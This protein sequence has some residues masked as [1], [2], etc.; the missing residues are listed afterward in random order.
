[1]TDAEQQQNTEA[2]AAQEAA[3]EHTEQQEQ[4]EQ[5]ETFDRAYVEKLRKENASYRQRAKE[6]QEAAE[7]AKKAAEREKLDEV[8]R[9]KAEKADLEKA[10]AE[11]KALATAA[12][13]RASLTGKVA[14]PSA[15]LKLLDE[16]EHLNEDGTVN[17]EALLKSFPFLKPAAPVTGTSVGGTPDPAGKGALKPSDFAGKSTEWIDANLHRLT[18]K[19]SAP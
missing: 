14:D 1:M 6:A 3:A 19:G 8:E 15:A 7:A 16:S 18:K 9:L 5:P 12:E 11:A 17:T 10:A 4:Q 13:R 2:Q